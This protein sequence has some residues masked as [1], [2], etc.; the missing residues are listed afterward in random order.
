MQRLAVAYSALGQHASGWLVL[1]GVGA[2][3]QPDRRA[4]WLRG[5]AKVA[6]AY[7]VNQTLKVLVRRPRPRVEGLP[8]L[9]ATPTQLSFPSAHATTSVTAARVYAGLLPAAPLRAAAAVMA[10]SRVYLGVHWPSDVAAG[11]ALG[12]VMGGRARQ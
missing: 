11:A 2:A 1:G 5:A 9:I 10:L 4:A 7:V 12:A 8:P 6:A 3:L